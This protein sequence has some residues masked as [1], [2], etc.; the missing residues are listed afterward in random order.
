MVVLGFDSVKKNK[1]IRARQIGLEILFFN[2]KISFQ[3]TKPIL[4]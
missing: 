4:N 2:Q 3:N 1:K